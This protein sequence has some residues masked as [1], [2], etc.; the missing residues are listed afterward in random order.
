MIFLEKQE[1][2]RGFPK[3]VCA[4]IFFPTNQ[5]ITQKF[6]L[7][8]ACFPSGNINKK[9]KLGLTL[10]LNHSAKPEL[11]FKRIVRTKVVYNLVIKYHFINRPSRPH[12]FP[13][14][15]DAY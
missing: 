7:I 15:G 13:A 11:I 2:F 10:L 8:F 14:Q 5:T 3:E 9:I 1:V 4:M 12:F 6:L